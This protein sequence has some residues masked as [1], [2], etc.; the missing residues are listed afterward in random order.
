MEHL[1]KCQTENPVNVGW[2]KKET[3]FH[4]SAGKAAAKVQKE[5]RRVKTIRT[6]SF[7]NNHLIK[8]H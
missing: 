7:E 6:S 3:Q 5:V 4:G 2:G 1:Y 8:N